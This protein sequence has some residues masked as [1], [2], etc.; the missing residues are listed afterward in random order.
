M[1]CLRY[2]LVALAACLA[3]LPP[4]ARA[5]TLVESL[6]LTGSVPVLGMIDTSSFAAFNPALGTLNS[7][8]VSLSGTLNYTGSGLPADEGG[9]LQLREDPLVTTA[10]GSDITA[11]LFFPTVGPDQSYD[12]ELP[13]MTNASVLSEYSGTGPRDFIIYD[14]GGNLTDL[15]TFL[16][17]SGTLT[18]NYTA[19][20]SPAPVPEPA[21]FALLGAAAV[22]CWG[23][24]RSFASRP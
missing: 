9:D 16:T 21:S 17:S 4:C 7:L 19:A 6:S 23:A 22:F 8:S 24:R 1:A 20:T 2:R 13:A 15:F 10:C 14:F 18:Y 5:T 3:L 12:F 11:C